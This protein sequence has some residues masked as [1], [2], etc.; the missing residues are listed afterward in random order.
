MTRVFALALL[1]VALGGCLAS[2]VGLGAPADA[3]VFRPEVFF[4]G[5]TRGEGTLSIRTR[6]SQPVRVESRGE[7]L[8]DGT[9]ELVQTIRLGDRAPTDRRW[10]FRRDGPGYAATLTEADGPVEIEVSGSELRLG[11]KTGRFSSIRQTLQLQPG[12]QVALNQ[13]TAYVLGIPVAR[14]EETIRRA[15]G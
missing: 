6:G 8:T 7:A 13:L 1:A 5:V 3:P 15:D 11:Y 14:L 12:G 9:F 10:T 2:H 4:D